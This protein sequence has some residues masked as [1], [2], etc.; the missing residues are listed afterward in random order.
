MLLVGR[1][2]LATLALREILELTPERFAEV[3]RRTAVKR[4]KL[5]GLLRNACVVAGNVGARDCVDVLVRLAEHDAPVVRAHAVWAV[6]RLGSGECLAQV[7]RTE[8]DV[9]VLAEYTAPLD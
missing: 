4:L 7:R 3:F 2:D 5:T 9:S 8:Q 1:S 6:R